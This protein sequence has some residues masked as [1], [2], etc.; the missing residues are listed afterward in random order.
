[1]AEGA[2]DV[3][4]QRRVD[5]KESDSHA[6]VGL[7]FWPGVTTQK[8]DAIFPSASLPVIEEARWL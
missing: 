7:S 2:F 3:G 1:V 8:C 4:A 5:V 6:E